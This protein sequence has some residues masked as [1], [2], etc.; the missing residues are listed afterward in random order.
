MGVHSMGV[1]VGA[2]GQL[3]GA[4]HGQAGGDGGVLRAQL[5]ARGVVLPGGG[6]GVPHGSD[7]TGPSWCQ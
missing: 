1:G 4:A 2:V 3:P 7:C 6:L 5:V